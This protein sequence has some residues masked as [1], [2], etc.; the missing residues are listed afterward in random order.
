MLSI[1]LFGPNKVWDKRHVTFYWTIQ[2]A[3]N[4]AAQRSWLNL[5][6]TLQH[7]RSTS[8]YAKLSP[9]ASKNASLSLRRVEAVVDDDDDDGD[10]VNWSIEHES[11]PV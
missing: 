5:S 4:K 7:S 10:E 9:S 6:L 1:S 11:R 2:F 8:P 3:Q